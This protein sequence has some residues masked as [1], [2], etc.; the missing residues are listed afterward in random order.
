VLSSGITTASYSTSA[1]LIA[2]TAYKFKV[3]SRNVFGFSTSTSN[4]I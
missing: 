2:N 1:N 4:E 3:K